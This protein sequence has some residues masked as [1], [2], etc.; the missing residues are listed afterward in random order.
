MGA[1]SRLRRAPQPSST[2]L[3]ALSEQRQGA[4]D[5]LPGDRASNT[6]EQAQQCK[7]LGELDEVE[8][9]H[10][11]TASKVRSTGVTIMVSPVSLSVIRNG[12]RV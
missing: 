6:R 5:Q 11:S 9:G 8:L 12:F 4:P 2:V 3:Q 7:A 1:S 10:Y